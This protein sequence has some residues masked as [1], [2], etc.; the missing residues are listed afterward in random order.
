MAIAWFIAL[1]SAIC[2]EGLG[3]KYVHGVP[4][5]AFYFLKDV[6]LLFGYLRFRP[7]QT[8]WRAAKYL[9]RGFQLAFMAAF[10]WTLIEVFNPDQLS[11]PLALVGLRAYWLWWLAPPVIATALQNARDKERAIY[12]LLAVS[13]VVA[14]FAAVQFA[15]PADSAINVYEGH[16]EGYEM[17]QVTVASTGRARVSSTFTFVSGF[18]DFTLAVPTLL[19]S[20]GLEAKKPRLRTLALAGTMVAAAVV[21][22]GGSRS[23]IVIG[24]AVLGL[25]IWSAGLFF[26]R[27]GRRVLIGGLAAAVISVVAFPDAML[28]VQSRF[29][30]NQEETTGRF[31]ETANI[32]PPVALVTFKYPMLGIGTGMQQNAR[33]SF[34]A[35]TAWDVESELGRYLVEL[36]PVGFIFFWIAKVGLTVAL[37]RAYK[38]LKR[39][40]RR[41]AAAAALSYAAMTMFES[42]TFDHNWQALYFLGCGFVLSD[43][44]AVLRQNAAT[45][46][47]RADEADQVVAAPIQALAFSADSHR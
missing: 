24:L 33:F 38:L 25:S 46:R 34:H 26:T 19:L 37:M 18:V 22:M 14:A 39:A 3:R 20:F 15:A 27:L 1:I 41:G 5:A 8:T 42:L 31:E 7:S 28:G 9:Y 4:D 44:L 23:S 2:F 17:G 45:I 6:I 10:V 12:A 13:L 35:S 43:V 16:G 30:Y 32:L 21:P 11:K 36:G 40:G 29:D 47:H